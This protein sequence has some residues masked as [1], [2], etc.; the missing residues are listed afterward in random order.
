MHVT[1]KQPI[2]QRMA[3]KQGQDPRAQ[4]HPVVSGC[5]NRG[6]V[7]QGNAF[8][9]AQRH[10][11]APGQSPDRHRNLKPFVGFGVLGKL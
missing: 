7:G 8:G 2:A 6:I 11:T 10:H 3:E 5:I 1:M 9:P 4:G